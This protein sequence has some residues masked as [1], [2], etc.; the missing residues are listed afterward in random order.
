MI[1]M[2]KPLI[3]HPDFREGDYWSRVEFKGGKEIIK[4]GETCDYLY[5]LEN[6]DVRVMG[7]VVLSEQRHVKPGVCD[8]KSGDVFGE[9]VMFDNQPRSASV[10][11]ISD[12]VLVRIHGKKAMIFLEQYPDLGFAILKELSQ[13]MVSR[14]RKTNQKFFS[15]LAWGLKAHGVERH[16]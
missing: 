5:L 12:C 3:E 8:L 14:L 6:G 1:S 9:M 10:V 2:F 16:L 4:L 13:N 15:L 7:D 11:A